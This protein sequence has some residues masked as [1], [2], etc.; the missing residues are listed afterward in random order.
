VDFFTFNFSREIASPVLWRFLP[1]AQGTFQK[2]SVISRLSKLI[3][4]P[5]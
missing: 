3:R 5:V 2:I 4:A 1:E